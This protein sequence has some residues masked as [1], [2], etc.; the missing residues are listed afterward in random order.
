MQHL[1]T[2]AAL[3]LIWKYS[4]QNDAFHFSNVFNI[5]TLINCEYRVTLKFRL[6][7]TNIS[8]GCLIRFF[9]IFF[10]AICKYSFFNDAR[11][12]VYSLTQ[13]FCD[14]LELWFSKCITNSSTQSS[15]FIIHIH[16][17]IYISRNFL[18][19]YV[20]N[21]YVHINLKN[22]VSLFIT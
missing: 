20:R 8:R 22:R 5:H 4:S 1:K 16:V 17:F 15:Q 13:Y 3:S 7:K 6:G 14:F 19:R 21:Y 12:C 2:Q 10:S 9:S 18:F 11:N